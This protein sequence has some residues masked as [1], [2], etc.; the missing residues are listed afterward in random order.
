MSIPI[1]SRVLVTGATGL[2]GSHAVRAL[3]DA[4]HGVRAFVRNPSKA[5]HLFPD[6]PAA[7]E[8][9]QGDIANRRSVEVALEG[10]DA[11]IH[12]AAM[13]AIGSASAPATLIETNVE[14]V[15]NVIGTAL[16]RGIERIVHVSS[17][18]PLFRNDGRP[19]TETS[20]P[21]PSSHAYGQSKMMAE[22]YVRELQAAEQPIQ[23][24]Y[25][26]AII[27]P[28]DPGLTA[29]MRS[30]QIFA[31]VFLPLTTSGIQY[32]D[33]RDLSDGLVR[34]IRD[35]P[36]ARRYLAAGQFIAWR[37]LASLL[38]RATGQRPPARR[39]SA[40]LL[41][42]AGRLADSLRSVVPI[43]LPLSLESATYVTRWNP[44]ENSE[45]FERLGV[46]FRSLEESMFDTVRWM[47]RAGHL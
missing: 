47:Q 27:G 19:I 7:L 34:M 8:V 15:R 45:G 23:I 22:A 40:P 20:E 46:E 43:E 31:Q 21:Q 41:R 24:L 4:G 39:V 1:P 38:E 33:V 26:G 29:S 17:I 32:V 5:S 25:P 30:V 12:C 16:K 36:K 9:A 35:E 6:A 2:L 18:A 14:G 28:D 42:F 13:V 37:D 11:L 10:C 3:L 44:I